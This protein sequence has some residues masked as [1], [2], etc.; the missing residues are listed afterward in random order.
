MRKK[1]SV[2]LAILMRARPLWHPLKIRHPFLKAVFSFM[3][4]E[5]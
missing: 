5:L 3:G 2:A 1:A 4:K